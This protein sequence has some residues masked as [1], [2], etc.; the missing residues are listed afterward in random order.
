MFRTGIPVKLGKGGKPRA[1][2]SRTAWPEGWTPWCPGACNY[3]V[4][5]A[6]V[7]HQ[8]HARREEWPGIRLGGQAA[9]GPRHPDHCGHE[10][11]LTK[12]AFAS[13]TSRR[14]KRP[15]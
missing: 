12:K 5:E 8:R 11:R 2:S 13:T 1:S 4:E 6:Y 3:D 14:S 7:G 10:A 15:A 9:G